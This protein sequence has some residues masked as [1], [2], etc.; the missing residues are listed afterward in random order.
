MKEYFSSKGRIRR[1]EY[2]YILATVV[3]LFLAGIIVLKAELE[4]PN[5][6]ISTFDLIYLVI[7]TILIW[8]ALAAGAKR[9]HD[10]GKTGYYQLIP[11]YIIWLMV[12]D[13]ENG[14]NIYGFPP[15][16]RLS[17]K[18]FKSQSAWMEEEA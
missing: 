17:Q 2:I 18:H 1:S 12:A 6:I 15:K 7:G 11:L 16:M 13:G 3:V 5:Y 14:K 8:A 10:M 4:E 9:C